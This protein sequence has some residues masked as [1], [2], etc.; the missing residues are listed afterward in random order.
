VVYTHMILPVILWKRNT[1]YLID[2]IPDGNV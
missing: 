1:I 2:R